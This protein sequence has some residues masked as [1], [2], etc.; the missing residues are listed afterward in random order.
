MD[1]DDNFTTPREPVDPQPV[2]AA[3]PASEGDAG[4]AGERGSD[5]GKWVQNELRATKKKGAGV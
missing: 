1:T 2:G 4:A 5:D 3:P